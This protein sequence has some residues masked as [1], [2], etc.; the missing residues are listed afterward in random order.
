MDSLSKFFIFEY[1]AINVI[2][3][4]KSNSSL[5]MHYLPKTK[6]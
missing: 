5:A 1:I 3:K 6:D 4:D 2:C